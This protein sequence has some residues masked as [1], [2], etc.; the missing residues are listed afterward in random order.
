MKYWVLKIFFRSELLKLNNLCIK[1]DREDMS[2]WQKGCIC[3]TGNAVAEL[4][5][6]TITK[7]V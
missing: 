6:K 1:I 3:G 7:E 5:G 4:S 2:E